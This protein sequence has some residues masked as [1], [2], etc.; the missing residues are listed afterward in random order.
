M[1]LNIKIYNTFLTTYVIEN[2]S[3]MRNII[4]SL[5]QF[6]SKLLEIQKV[7]VHHSS[8]QGEFLSSRLDKLRRED[9]KETHF[10]QMLI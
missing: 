1:E 2:L 6:C 3:W 8:V 9:Q 4:H 5:L 10:L 7:I